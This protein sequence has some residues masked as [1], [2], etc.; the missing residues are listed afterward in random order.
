MSQI[1]YLQIYSLQRDK[2]LSLMISEK[3]VYVFEIHELFW[4]LTENF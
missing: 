2:D 3:Y 4:M 1:F